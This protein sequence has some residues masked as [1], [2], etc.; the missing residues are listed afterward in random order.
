MSGLSLRLS[1]QDR[2]IGFDTN[3]PNHPDSP[4]R[5]IYIDV[6]LEIILESELTNGPLVMWR[7][8]IS[9]NEIEQDG[10]ER[11]GYYN[12]AYYL[13]NLETV[14]LLDKIAY[15]TELTCEYDFDEETL[16]I[17][18]DCIMGGCSPIRVPCTC[19]R[20]EELKA[21]FLQHAKGLMIEHFHVSFPSGD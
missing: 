8:E 5:T 1:F 2:F 9:S 10:L 13:E 17:Y 20:I 16:T 4:Q 19:E 7:R 6:Y 15:D 18:P 3:D 12:P 14:N 21:D 11:G